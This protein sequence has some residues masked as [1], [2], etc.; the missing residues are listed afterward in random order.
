MPAGC[1]FWLPE[2]RTI[3]DIGAQDSK[4]IPDGRKREVTHFRHE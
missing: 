2:V 1:V 3:I 4:V